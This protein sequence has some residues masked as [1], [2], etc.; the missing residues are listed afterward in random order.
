MEILIYILYLLKSQQ[1]STNE[2]VCK[3]HQYEEQICLLDAN[4]ANYVEMTTHKTRHRGA[5][6]FYLFISILKS[7][8]IIRLLLWLQA[9][10]WRQ[11]LADTTEKD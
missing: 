9:E 11:L 5:N 10:Q 1:Q 8:N 6:G 7:I 3:C 2:H 4:T